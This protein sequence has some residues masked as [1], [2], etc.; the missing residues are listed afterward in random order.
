MSQTTEIIASVYYT[1]VIVYIY[2]YTYIWNRLYR[3]RLFFIFL[4]SSSSG[5]VQQDL[6]LCERVRQEKRSVKLERL[7]VQTFLFYS[8]YL[9]LLFISFFFSRLTSDHIRTSSLQK[10][11]SRVWPYTR[12]IFPWLVTTFQRGSWSFLSLCEFFFFLFSATLCAV[13]RYGEDWI[14][15][16][17]ILGSR[18]LYLVVVL[19]SPFCWWVRGCGVFCFLFFFFVLFSSVKRLNLLNEIRMKQPGWWSRNSRSQTP[20][21][22]WDRCNSYALSVLFMLRI[23]TMS[24][25]REREKNMGNNNV[26]ARS[27]KNLIST[28]ERERWERKKK[29]EKQLKNQK[30]E[31]SRSMLQLEASGVL[32]LLP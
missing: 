8:D 14:S 31:N 22:A 29:K 4:S 28:V 18:W 16:A 26:S 6:L 27:E 23:D 24:L 21:R 13:H 5:C 11:F 15:W 1:C 30:K 10:T 19:L 20:K 12:Y 32:V 2:L 25:M 9:L 3:Q 17:Y 7:C